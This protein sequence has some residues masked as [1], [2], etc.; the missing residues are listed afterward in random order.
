MVHNAAKSLCI[1]Q[2]YENN[3][4]VK[5]FLRHSMLYNIG[6]SFMCTRAWIGRYRK[7]SAYNSFLLWIQLLLFL[8]C[9]RFCVIY[10]YIY[11]Y[12]RFN[13]VIIFLINYNVREWFST[14]GVI[15]NEQKNLLTKKKNK[16]YKVNLQQK[17]T[18][19]HIL[20]YVTMYII[21]LTNFDRNNYSR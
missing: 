20:Y 4:V 11:L 5:Y 19:V 12:S 8:C 21:M 6:T 1:Y 2:V 18:N 17:Y 10:I 13:V 16:K 9:M 14:V 3:F 15:N 7:F